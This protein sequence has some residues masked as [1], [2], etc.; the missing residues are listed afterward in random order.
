MKL[1]LECIRA[2]MLTLEENLVFENDG[3][4]F[5]MKRLSLER[6]NALL[7]AFSK[8]DI[9]YSIYNLEQAGYLAVAIQLTGGGG[10]YY[11]DVKDITYRGHEFL[12]SIRDEKRWA[13]VKSVA[14][15]VRD[16]SL[17]AI[18]SI[19]EGATSAAITTYFSRQ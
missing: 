10:V 3:E 14:D 13:K 2:V 18:S 8:E 1:D 15:A 17:A 4:C 16:Y 19:A 6:I 9:F 7:P 12:N 11:C 5:W